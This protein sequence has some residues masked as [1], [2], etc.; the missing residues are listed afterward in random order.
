MARMYPATFQGRGNSGDRWEK[1]VYEKLSGLPDGITVIH[2]LKWIKENEP[3]PGESDFIVV[4]PSRRQILVLEVKGGQE[5]KV[6]HNEWKVKPYGDGRFYPL[7]KSPIEQARDSGYA[8]TAKM[9]ETEPELFRDHGKLCAVGIVLPGATWGSGGI[10]HDLTRD[11]VIDGDDIANE[12]IYPF[13]ARMFDKRGPKE[14]CEDN[15]YA[16]KLVEFLCPNLDFVPSM[17]SQMKVNERAWVQL[18]GQQKAI[19]GLMGKT[20]RLL[21]NGVA[22]SGKTVIALEAAYR[23]AKEG[24]KALYLCRNTILAAEMFSRIRESYS[25]ECGEGLI[26]AYSYEAKCSDILKR[27][28]A[29]SDKKYNKRL[30]SKISADTLAGDIRFDDIYVDE[31]QEFEETAWQVVKRLLKRQESGRLWVFYDPHQVVRLEGRRNLVDAVEKPRWGIVGRFWTALGRRP[32]FVFTDH[33]TVNFRN[34]RKI[35]RVASDFV[36][37][38]EMSFPHGAP[39]GENV[40]VKDVEPSCVVCEVAEQIWKWVEGGIQEHRIALFDVG[41][42]GQGDDVGSLRQQIYRELGPDGCK[43]ITRGHAHG[44]IG[45]RERGDVPLFTSTDRF[46]GVEA[47]AVVLLVPGAPTA[48][49][50]RNLVNRALYVGATRARHFLTVIRVEET[51]NARSGRRSCECNRLLERIKKEREGRER[52]FWRAVNSVAWARIACHWEDG[53]ENQEERFKRLFGGVVAGVRK[54]LSRPPFTATE[55][56]AVHNAFQANFKMYGKKE[57]RQ[58]VDAAWQSSERCAREPEY[59]RRIGNPKELDIERS[60]YGKL[61]NQVRQA[62]RRRQRLNNAEKKTV[63]QVFWARV[64]GTILDLP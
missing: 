39:E 40:L 56:N 41:A 63:C 50:G 55:V 60:D 29:E 7:K 49:K 16:E 27:H 59:A 57:W 32:A 58:L 34:T 23:S 12:N 54:V 35:G 37:Q 25:K 62:C 11:L 53:N 13:I 4:D 10:P 8:L 21:V 64:C 43:L 18:D 42:A 36:D 28:D 44:V 22:G 46:K 38:V 48:E 17:A 19:L 51:P 9:K 31:G 52:H 5:F 20:P 30:L 2:S 33:L 14:T 1:L 6:A 47:D 3:A 24:R 26:Q 15:A 45:T 61:M